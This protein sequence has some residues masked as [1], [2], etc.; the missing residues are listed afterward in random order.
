MK[1]LWFFFLNNHIT[2]LFG[3]VMF[4]FACEFYYKH[5]A[6][7]EAADDWFEAYAFRTLAK[8]YGKRHR[9]YVG[10]PIHLSKDKS[11]VYSDGEGNYTRVFKE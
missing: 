5:F 3:L 8:K 10:Q 2:I 1:E 4:M 9:E 7:K 6:K 11:M